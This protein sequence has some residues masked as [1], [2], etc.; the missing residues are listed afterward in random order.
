MITSHTH[1]KSNGANHQYLR[2]AP[3]Y[4][5]FGKS[6]VAKIITKH[7][8]H[9]MLGLISPGV[10]TYKPNAGTFEVLK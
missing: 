10:G 8:D 7:H 3:A 6:P 4:T 5:F 2:N 1:N 9:E